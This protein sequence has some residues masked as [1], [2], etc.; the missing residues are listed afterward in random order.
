VRPV[1]EAD[2][3]VV[4]SGSGGGVPQ[5]RSRR[6]A[7]ASSSSRRAATTTN[8]TSCSQ[9]WL[10]IKIS[11]F[12]AGSSPPPMAWSASRRAAPW[13]AAARVNWSNSLLTPEHRS[14]PTG[15]GGL[16]DVDTPA[17]DEHLQAV[18]KRIQCNDKVATQNGPHERLSEGA[19]KLG[20]AYRVAT[21]NIDPEK[22]DPT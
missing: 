7:D 16:T 8:P 2:V 1:L 19:S 14:L 13:A 21:L 12:A 10:R 17:F 4:G 3:V 15:R 11:S 6:Q 22:Y 20:Y 9:R 5:Q 18:F